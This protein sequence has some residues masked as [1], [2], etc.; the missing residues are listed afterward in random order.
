MTYSVFIIFSILLLWFIILL[1]LLR[2]FYLEGKLK[3]GYDVIILLSLCAS[4]IIVI[5][6]TLLTT[7]FY[8]YPVVLKGFGL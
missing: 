8:L 2:L 1:P 5:I 6:I 7:L 3:Y 4:I